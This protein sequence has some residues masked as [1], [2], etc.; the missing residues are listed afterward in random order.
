MSNT[1]SDS[2]AIPFMGGH[3]TMAS[4]R[5]PT[6]SSLFD[7]A[8]T[9]SKRATTTTTTTTVATTVATTKSFPI[10]QGDNPL[11]KSLLYFKHTKLYMERNGKRLDGIRIT[12]D[13]PKEFKA[14]FW[15]QMGWALTIW[16]EFV[17][18]S[19]DA[20][21]IRIHVRSYYHLNNYFNKYVLGSRPSEIPPILECLFVAEGRY[22]GTSLHSILHSSFHN[23]Y[24]HKLDKVHS[25]THASQAYN[26]AM[27]HPTFEEVE[28]I[29][30]DKS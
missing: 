11:N 7:E 20:S 21:L 24:W 22:K 8:L 13:I 3:L 18:R 29:R 1:T 12:S 9:T 26:L 30:T 27:L 19:E 4:V 14:D 25:C 28:A 23:D 15:L 5:S 17:I 6:V 2:S 10:H 16:P